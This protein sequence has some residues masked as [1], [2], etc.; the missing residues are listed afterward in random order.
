MDPN[1]DRAV[2]AVFDGYAQ[3]NDA[4]KLGRNA[5]QEDVALEILRH[6]PS[7][8]H[9]LARE[10]LARLPGHEQNAHAPSGTQEK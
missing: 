3:F 8:A 10:Y 2:Q 6:D 5:G 9:K 1:Q 7:L 4:F